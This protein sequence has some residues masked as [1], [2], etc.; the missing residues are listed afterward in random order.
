MEETEKMGEDVAIALI[1]DHPTP[2]ELK[3]H[4]HDPVPF[5]IYHPGENPDSVLTYDEETTKNG[6]YGLLKGNEFIKA[7]LVYR[8]KIYFIRVTDTYQCENCFFLLRSLYCCV[9]DI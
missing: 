1:P 4:T 3:T 5:I 8:Y 2:C 6:Y 7:L 9:R